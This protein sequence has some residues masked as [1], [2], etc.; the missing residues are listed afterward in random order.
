MNARDEIKIKENTFFK[1]E[2][3]EKFPLINFL[4]KAKGN[5]KTQKKK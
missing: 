4:N 2:K 3:S 5:E 1:K